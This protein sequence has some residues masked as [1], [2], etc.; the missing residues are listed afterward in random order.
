MASA[1]KSVRSIVLL[2]LQGWGVGAQKRERQGSVGSA[3][4]LPESTPTPHHTHSG[5]CGSLLPL[6]VSEL[7]Q[8]A[9]SQ[10]VLAWVWNLTL[11]RL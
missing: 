7:A 8:A 6:D 10:E 3:S 9:S 2:F 5:C 4:Q 1:A 11:E